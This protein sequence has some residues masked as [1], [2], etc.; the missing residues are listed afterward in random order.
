VAAR[1][2][3]SRTALVPV[4]I[5]L[6]GLPLHRNILHWAL[7]AGLGIHAELLV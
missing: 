7:I 5:P 3:G 4:V 6:V 2:V 1:L